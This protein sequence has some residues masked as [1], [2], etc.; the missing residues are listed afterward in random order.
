MVILF[1]RR[2]PASWPHMTRSLIA[3]Y[4]IAAS[5]DSISE[6]YFSLRRILHVWLPS[7]AV[8][9]LH[10]V[11]NSVF[12]W[13]GSASRR[14]VSILLSPRHALSAEPFTAAFRFSVCYSG[15]ACAKRY[16]TQGLHGKET[17]HIG[18]EMPRP[19]SRFR[20]P[21]VGLL[22]YI[23]VVEHS[24]LASCCGDDPS[25]RAS[26]AVESPIGGAAGWYSERSPASVAA[27]QGRPRSTLRT[28]WFLWRLC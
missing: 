16:Y 28:T 7:I 11:C 8:L 13:K 19:A 4:P 6:F 1:A 25:P 21:P 20:I 15:L 24:A 3:N 22:R 27:G 23:V 17:Y 26:S 9:S 18:W 14:S 2:V 12:K 5:F 10:H